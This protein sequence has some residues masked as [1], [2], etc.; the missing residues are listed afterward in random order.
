MKSNINNAIVELDTVIKTLT[1]LSDCGILPKNST[2]D[3]I[4]VINNAKKYLQEDEETCPKCG[5][6]GYADDID[7]YEEAGFETSYAKKFECSECE[8]TWTAIYEIQCVNIYVDDELSL[9]ESLIKLIE[10]YYG[11]EEDYVYMN[12]TCLDMWSEKH[13]VANE[14]EQYSIDTLNEILEGEYTAELHQE[15]PNA[16]YEVKFTKNKIAD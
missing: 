5:A 11:P 3:I 13:G 10:E 12:E 4:E 8:T 1:G 14:D 16:D 9:K 6:E 2:G 7:T 15:T